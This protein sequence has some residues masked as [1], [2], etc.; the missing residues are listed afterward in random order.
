MTKEKL[1]AESKSHKKLGKRQLESIN[2]VN[3][4]MTNLIKSNFNKK[5]SIILQEQWA[6]QGQTGEFNF[7]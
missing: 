4:E 1:H 5:I 7:I 6:K 2:Q 3:N